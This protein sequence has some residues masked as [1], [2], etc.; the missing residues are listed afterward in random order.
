[1]RPQQFYT[2]PTALVIVSLLA[3]G[4]AFAD[5]SS[6]EAQPDGPSAKLWPATV[7][8]T[9]G[10]AV[11][12]VIEVCM[13][14]RSKSIQTGRAQGPE[15]EQVKPVVE[16]KPAVFGTD[17]AI[18]WSVNG[19]AG[20]SEAT[21][22]VTPFPQE[23]QSRNI[24]RALY[25]A[26]VKVLGKPVAVSVEYEPAG[27]AAKKMAL[28]R[29]VEVIDLPT[30]KEL[31]DID[32]LVG[33]VRFDYRFQGANHKKDILALNQMAL[34]SANLARSPESNPQHIIW[35]GRPQHFV[36]L[37]DVHGMAG[38]QTILKDKGSPNDRS[39]LVVTLKL[40]DCTYSAVLHVGVDAAEA[41]NVMGVAVPV[42]KGDVQAGSVHLGNRS[43]AGGLSGSVQATAT[44]RAA[45]NELEDLYC[46]GGL[47]S[48]FMAQGFATEET[49]GTATISWSLAP[50]K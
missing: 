41:L 30:C 2:L 10:G 26:P 48:S 32:Q 45:A 34:V 23:D 25:R 19:V 21:G 28:S 31:P 46:P 29:D 14:L 37:N 24:L 20:G 4:A 36:S 6:P 35:R 13:P 15:E 44:N 33:H 39:E 9:T 43:I 27:S 47:G 42:K 18:R 22:T 1:M 5:L 49:S 3:F 50:A 12:L 16:C 11:E 17:D 40:S 7:I 38:A 8:V